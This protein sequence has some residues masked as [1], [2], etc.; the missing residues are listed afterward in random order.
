MEQVSREAAKSAK[1]KPEQSFAPFAASRE[2]SLDLSASL[3]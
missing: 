1:S 3:A 2:P